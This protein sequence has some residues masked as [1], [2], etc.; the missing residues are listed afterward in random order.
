MA[1]WR[2]MSDTALSGAP[3][4]FRRA[5]C[6]REKAMHQNVGA[7]LRYPLDLRSMTDAET[8]TETDTGTDA[9]DG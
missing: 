5:I 8:D 1:A 3:F 4:G 2:G 6:G 9:E 7:I